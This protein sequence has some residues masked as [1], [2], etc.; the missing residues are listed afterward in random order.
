MVVCPNSIASD[1]H[2]ENQVADCRWKFVV[3]GIWDRYWEPWSEETVTWSNA[4][5]HRPGE[6]TGKFFGPE[7]PID[8][9]EFSVYQHG[10]AGESVEIS[11]P[12]LLRF[13]RADEDGAVNFLVSRLTGYHWSSPGGNNEDRVVHS[14]ASR[15]H[16]TL[17]GPR[18][19]LWLDSESNDD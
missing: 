7:G 3:G 12:Q 6:I 16:P 1:L 13:L 10:V 8:L 11:G 14:F 2:P 17:P 15:E 18:L 5:G 9:G 19:E 4:P